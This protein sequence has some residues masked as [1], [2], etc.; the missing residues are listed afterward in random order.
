[1]ECGACGLS[2]AGGAGSCP[3][4]GAAAGGE[5]E[6]GYWRLRGLGY[7]LAAGLAVVVGA[8]TCR[9]VIELAGLGTA[10]WRNWLIGYHLNEFADI[11]VF[12]LGI[13]FVIWFR[14]ARGNAGHSGWRQRR[15]SSWALWGWIVPVA[16]L[17]IP[18]QLMGDIW[19]A[20]LPAA[21]RRKTAWLPALWWATFLTGAASQRYY[22]WPHLSG[23]TSPAS[24]CLLAVSGTALI[25]IILI[26]SCGPV[27]S[28]Q[29]ALPDRPAEPDRP[30]RRRG[31]SAPE[32]ARLRT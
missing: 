6:P 32:A 26:V 11:T 29:P 8:I 24:L 13:I 27:G 10:R 16:N 4:C 18:F 17:W 30:D 1:V 14:M 21:R 12:F 2:F 7:V 23:G 9:L 31:N 15:A 20:G 3:G 22:P 28:P 25:A 19:R 5:P